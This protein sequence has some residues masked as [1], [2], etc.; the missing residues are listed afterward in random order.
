[1]NDPIVA[2]IDL[3]LREFIPRPKISVHETHIQ[4]PR[5]PVVDAHNHPG[6]TF[7]G[8]WYWEPVPELLEVM[9]AAG[10]RLLVDQ[11]GGWGEAILAAI[12]FKSLR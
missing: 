10:V 1:M 5:F 3:P 2:P 6:D 7:S 12:K 11:D 8:G 4:K 9:D